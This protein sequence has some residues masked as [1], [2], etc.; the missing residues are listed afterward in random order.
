MEK[1]NNELKDP[2]HFID[3][4]GTLYPWDKD[5]ITTEEIATLGGWNVSDGVLMIDLK[6]NEEVTLQPGQVIDVKPGMGFSKK[7]RFKRG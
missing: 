7:H 1:E 5:T 3:I 2:K 6:T 4:E